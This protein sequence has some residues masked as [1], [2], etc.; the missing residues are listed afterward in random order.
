M[1]DQIKGG[2]FGVAIGDALGVTTE[3]LTE[4]EIREKYGYVK[5]MTG[6]GFWG[7]E[8]GETT[9]DTAMTM[10]VAKGIIKNPEDPVDDIGKEFIAWGN[11]KPKTI[12]NTIA[13]TFRLFSGD[14]FEAAKMAHDTFNGKSA[15]NGSLMRCLP[16][17]LLYENEQKMIDITIR[18]SKMTHY[19]D[20][21]AEACVI[22]NKI[23]RRLLKGE[24][25]R[26][27]IQAEIKNTCYDTDLETEPDCPPDGYVVHTLKWAIYWLYNENSFRDVVLG[28][29]NKGGDSDTIAAV[30]GGLKGVHTGYSRIPDEYKRKIVIKEELDQLAANIYRLRTRELL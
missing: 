30:A 8:P 14:W 11:T 1:L 29:V 19:D 24:E 9:D 22:Y 21:A 26:P 10:A 16:V 25:L 5:E 23:A 13:A 17:A 28:A 20:K 2:L 18:Q 27:G 4:K 7:L 12:G 15:G 6:G 3:F